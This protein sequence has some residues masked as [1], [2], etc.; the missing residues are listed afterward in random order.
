[1]NTNT[2]NK[3]SNLGVIKPILLAINLFVALLLLISQ[4]APNISPAR[5]WM[6]ELF[7][8]SYPFLLIV[9]IFFILYWLLRF[10]RF[11]LISAVV[12]IMG[13]D[14]ITQLYRPNLFSLDVTPPL[15]SIKIMSYNV[16][17]F[18]LYNWTG[19]MKTR[20]KIFSLISKEQPTILCFQ[21]YYQTE[22][23]K[24]NFENN[25]TISKLLNNAYRHV[26]Y[27]ITLR[28]T[29][30][31]GLAT[32]S[33]YPI[34]GGGKVFYVQNKSNFGM[35]SDI[36]FEGDTIRV[37][38]LH[39][40][41]NHFKEE[42]YE[43]LDNPDSGSNE[44]ILNGAHNIIGRLKRASVRRSLQVEELSADLLLC[45]YPYIICG[46]FNDPPFSY[47]YESISKNL[48]D[49][50]VEK[51]KGFGLTYSGTFAPYRIDY[52]LHQDNF[53]TYRFDILKSNLSDHYPIIAWFDYKK[54]S[55]GN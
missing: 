45:K 2:T 30:H 46:D 26:E 22:N 33:K 3:N 42:D 19:N 4:V 13:Y 48:N 55:K 36:L 43:F 47:T 50:F 10:H 15:N 24:N 7:A 27:G 29:D 38:N 23:P 21:E 6:L 49:A 8:I 52:I 25:D 14:K 53:K 44:H 35:Y 11:A 16:R 9:N 40:Q 31:W 5:F 17:L 41:S 51:G 39:L 1:M 37:Y 32:F 12:I 54:K 20:S 34:V 28:K 18:D